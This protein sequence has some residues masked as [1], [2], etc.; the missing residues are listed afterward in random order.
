MNKL[1]GFISCMALAGCAQTAQQNMN[2]D[3]IH[4]ELGGNP[5]I[6]NMYSADPSAHVF[7]DSLYIYPSHDED[8][9]MGFDMKDYHVYVTADL[10]HFEDK[11]VIFSPFEQTTWAK[12]AAWA[13]DCVERNGK[14]YLYFP[15]DKKHIGVAVADRPEGPFKDALGHPLLSIDTPGVICDRDFIDPCCFIDDDGQAYLFVGQNTCC[16]IKL[17]EDMISYDGEV[18]IIE[19][20]VEFFEASWVHKYN[21]K[22]YLS[23]SNSALTGHQPEIVYAMSDNP[24][25][26]YDYK[27]SILGPVSSGTN[28]HSIVKYGADW[29][30]FYHTGDLGRQNWP[31]NPVMGAFH[32]SVCV[33]YLYYNEDGT[34]KPVIPTRDEE[35]IKNNTA[36]K[37]PYDFGR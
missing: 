9:A 16:C 14:Y 26:P 30:L 37:E 21:G 36:F 27:G 11:G 29:L 12:T 28:H 3:S 2:N 8:R 31:D 5:I 20:L 25:G 24:L 32:R 7:G 17:N 1:I 13:P 19:G 33:D 35:K 4:H 15:T 23:Y 10:Q 18:H 6:T 34:I 22:Y